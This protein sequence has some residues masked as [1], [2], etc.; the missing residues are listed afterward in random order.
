MSFDQ[1]YLSWWPI[2]FPYGRSR[3]PVIAPFWAD[4]DYRNEMPG[5]RVF[6]QVYDRKKNSPLLR[7]TAVLDEFSVRANFRAEWMLVVTWKDAVPW[8]YWYYR[9]FNY[10][11][12][13]VS[14]YVPTVCSNLFTLVKA[15]DFQAPSSGLYE[16][17]YL[18]TT[19][20]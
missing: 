18:C 8:P 17:G 1:Q 5:S 2:P 11:Y 12:G 15:G 13:G 4:F 20:I 3:I 7:E 14:M 19:A 6:Y 9:Y 16:A 10:A